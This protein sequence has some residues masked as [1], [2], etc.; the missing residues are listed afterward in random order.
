VGFLLLGI[1][2]VAQLI[3]IVAFVT[4]LYYAAI[5]GYWL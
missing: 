5:R 4:F 1:A 2:V 3:A